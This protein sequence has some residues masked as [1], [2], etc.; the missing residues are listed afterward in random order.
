MIDKEYT[1][2]KLLLLT[3]GNNAV[4]RWVEN[5]CPDAVVID[6]AEQDKEKTFSLIVDVTYNV[7][8]TYRCPYI[9]P[10]AFYDELPM[11][12][13]NIHPSLLPKYKGLNPWE[14]MFR[15]KETEGGVTLHRLSDN[16]DGGEIMWQ[17]T[18]DILSTDTIDTAR[19]KADHIAGKI[20]HEFLR[21]QVWD[22]LQMHIAREGGGM[23]GITFDREDI[24]VGQDLVD[25]APQ[26]REAY[27][28]LRVVV[29]ECGDGFVALEVTNSRGLSVKTDVFIAERQVC[30]SINAAGELGV[31]LR[32]S[33]M[34]FSERLNIYD[35]YDECWREYLL[36]SKDLEKAEDGDAKAAYR[37]AESIA[38]QTPESLEVIATY[39]TRAAELGN[40][41]AKDWLYDYYHGDDGRFDPYS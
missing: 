20:A 25:R 27:F 39:M 7:L 2:I 11:G 22:M 8:V 5:H 29:T 3:T 38:E 4:R 18:F 15:N 16:V 32:F 23:V 30:Q 35:D 12:G 34:S 10:K 33:L 28:E 9:L 41:E 1:Y 37:V 19:A 13:Y 24:K 36:D 31:E 21:T 14:D 17:E 6:C 26:L 40:K